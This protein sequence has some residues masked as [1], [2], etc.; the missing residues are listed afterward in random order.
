MY[1]GGT[2]LAIGDSI[3]WHSIYNLTNPS[4]SDDSHYGFQVANWIR[5]NKGNIQFINK[6]SGGATSLTTRTN[7]VFW[8][9]IRA[10][11]ATIAL[12][13]NDS[14][15]AQVSVANY[16][17][18]LTAIVARLRV[19]NPTV[20]IV[21]CTPSP[22][23][24]GNRSTIDDYVT[25][26]VSLASSLNTATSPVSVARFDQA[27]TTSN[28][29]LKANMPSF[30]IQSITATSTLMTV[31]ATAHGLSTGSQITIR[32]S[33]QPTYNVTYNSGTNTPVITLVNANQFTIAGTGFSTA[34]D[35][36]AGMFGIS[37]VVHPKASGHILMGQLL[38][39]V[40]QN[41]AWLDKLGDVQ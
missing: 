25:A 7:K 2:Y 5:T 8:G 41:D 10:D 28:A 22:T 36:T 3:T 6:G 16:T 32:G 35:S 26:V 34:G 33:A 4:L 12:G 37:D 30:N 27:W 38:T 21:L 17:T 18:N 20:R 11:F 29:D 40:I 13:M 23:V 24:D 15:A 19:M 31:N 1:R 14:A 9:S 39:S